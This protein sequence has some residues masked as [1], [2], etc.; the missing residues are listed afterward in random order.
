MVTTSFGVASALAT[1]PTIRIRVC[2]GEYDPRDGGVTGPDTINYLGQFSVAH[3][4]I[5]ASRLDADGPSDFNSGSVW[6]KRTMIKQAEQAI[7]VL[8][9]DKLDKTASSAS[10]DWVRSVTSSPTKPRRNSLR[11][12]SPGRMSRCTS[13]GESSSP[14]RLRVQ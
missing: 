8:D 3:A 1:N 14:H 7:L 5:G 13:P 9:H 12:R 6:I 4:V 2:P 10:A 11:R